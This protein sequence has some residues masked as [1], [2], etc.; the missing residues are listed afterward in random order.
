MPP[1]PSSRSASIREWAT[2]ATAEPVTAPRSATARGPR[3]VRPPPTSTLIMT[4]PDARR[5]NPA[6]VSGSG[7]PTAGR[8]LSSTGSAACTR[9]PDHEPCA[10]SG[11]GQDRAAAPVDRLRHQRRARGRGPP[12]GPR[13]RLRRPAPGGHR[14]ACST[15]SPGPVSVTVIRTPPSASALATSTRRAPLGGLRGQH[16]ERVVDQVAQDRH[17]LVVRRRSSGSTDPAPMVSSMPRS[18]ACADLASSN[19]ATARLPTPSSTRSASAC[20]VSSSP[21][22]KVSAWSVSPEFD[23]RDDGVQ[24]VRRLVRL[25]PQRVRK[26]L[27]PIEFAAQRLQL[28][29]V[30]QGDRQ[31]RRACPCTTH[32]TAADQQHPVVGAAPVRR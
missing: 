25:R 15:V 2:P 7:S 8:L 14:P 4:G 20:A 32:R 12:A 27:R 18:A 17:Q 16:V 9:Q 23:Q 13:R 3:S 19:A 24:P 22:A 28:G 11:L 31:R 1:L 30:A 29:V 5:G 10:R 6:A 21:T 26:A